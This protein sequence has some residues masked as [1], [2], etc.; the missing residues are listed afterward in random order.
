MQTHLAAAQAGQAPAPASPNPALANAAVRVAVDYG[1]AEELAG[2]LDKLAKGLASGNPAIFKMLR[3]QGV[4]LGRGPAPKVAFLYTGQGSQYV[5]MLAALRQ[6]E[7]I[8]RDRFARAD[9]VMAPLLG[10]PLSEFIFTDPADEARVKE[11]TKGCLLYTSRC[12]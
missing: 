5:N 10:K 1:N 2:K 3:Q 6:T 12:V 7:T 4:F 8:V 11:L 9:L